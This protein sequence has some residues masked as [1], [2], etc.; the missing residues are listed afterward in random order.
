M[1]GLA[2]PPALNDEHAGK[3]GGGLD[4]GLELEPGVQHGVQVGRQH[5]VVSTDIHRAALGSEQPSGTAR[6]EIATGASAF[7][8]TPPPR[9]TGWLESNGCLCGGSAR[10]NAPILRRSVW[11]SRSWIGKCR[12]ATL[13]KAMAL[14]PAGYQVGSLNKT[15]P[16]QRTLEGFRSRRLCGMALLG[17]CAVCYFTIPKPP[18]ADS[19]GSLPAQSGPAQRR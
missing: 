13:I 8:V 15:S 6:T 11:R 4:E 19:Q 7:W 9:A 5:P 2:R 18:S 3:V 16:A 1:P 10:L 12:P 17:L 14:H